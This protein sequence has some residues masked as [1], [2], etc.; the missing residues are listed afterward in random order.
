MMKNYRLTS[1]LI[2]YLIP[3]MS[4][5]IFI[6]DTESKQH[7]SLVKKFIQN[8]LDTSNYIEPI[9]INENEFKIKLINKLNLC[10]KSKNL[11]E[12][13]K[14]YILG[15]M[16]KDTDILG[17][18]ILNVNNNKGD[19]GETNFE[20]AIDDKKAE[21]EL[22]CL[23]MPSY[24]DYLEEM[25]RQV[26]CTLYKKTKKWIPGHRYDTVKETIFF[27]GTVMSR[28]KDRHNSEWMTSDKMIE[29]YL[30]TNKLDNEKSISEVLNNRVFG[31]RPE[32]LKVLYTTTAMV[33]SGEVLINDFN[34]GNSQE[35][36]F[37]NGIE[38]YKFINEFGKID[39]DLPNILEPLS[40]TDINDKNPDLS[41]YKTSLDIIINNELLDHI[42][43]YWDCTTNT[44]TDRELSS[45]LDLNTNIANCEK[46]LYY[47]IKDSNIMK[48]LYYQEL[49][50]TIG[51]NIH[52]LI[53]HKLSSGWNLK[54]FINNFDNFLKYGK[55]YTQSHVIPNNPCEKTARLR[56]EKSC[57]FKLELLPL[58][59]S[60]DSSTEL[61]CMLINMINFAKENY[62]LGVSHYSITNTGTIKSP[63]EFITIIITLEDVLK[64]FKT[65]LEIP[66]NLKNDI[67]NY[68]F[69]RLTLTADKDIEIK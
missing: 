18:I 9:E 36:L 11:P 25:R 56:T 59:N 63:K 41:K 68:N 29:T 48:T 46:L 54:Q 2:A 20:I 8:N 21:V 50:K 31:D 3:G 38:Y 17:E 1:N 60:I 67:V 15:N 4:D 53:E 10:I 28:R 39:Y 5:Y 34:Y 66:E 49:F 23:G 62:G 55:I 33:D 47:N 40:Y 12:P 69:L 45:K 24:T 51:I 6:S 57:N 44:R 19:F 14:W 13:E 64:K 42:V 43:N 61:Y 65:P 58:E 35:I 37:N 27:L 32:D 16:T 26:N 7:Q 52:D 30:I 22:V